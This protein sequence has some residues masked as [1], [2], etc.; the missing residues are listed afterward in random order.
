VPAEDD[1]STAERGPGATRPIGPAPQNRAVVPSLSI[2]GIAS[3]DC[4]VCGVPFRAYGPETRVHGVLRVE[5]ACH[6]CLAEHTLEIDR[7]RGE[8]SVRSINTRF[9]SRPPA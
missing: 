3:I 4:P 9:P 6:A 2:D 5:A 1:R 8:T 7:W